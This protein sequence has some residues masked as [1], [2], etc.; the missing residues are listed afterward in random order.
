M[1]NTP[2]L[3]VSLLVLLS[4]PVLPA[5]SAQG[6]RVLERVDPVFPMDVTLSGITRGAVRCV[7]DVDAHG[8]VEDVLITEYTHPSFGRVVREAMPLWKFHPAVLD[9]QPV[10]SQTS[11]VFTIE[12]VGVVVTLDQSAYVRNRFETIWGQP[13]E[14]RTYSLQDLDRIPEPQKTVSPRYPQEVA[15]RNIVGRVRVDFY[16]DEQGRVRMPIV[17]PGVS[18]ELAGAAVEAIRQWQFSPPRRQGSPVLVRASQEFNFN[19]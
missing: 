15:Q 2:L 6:L 19:P 4:A 10:P 18:R 8:K 11:L 9:G 13:Y 5:L 16:I 14:Y 7:V 12:A 3:L 1:K 17:L